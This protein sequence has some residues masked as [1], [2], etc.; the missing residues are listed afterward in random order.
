MTILPALHRAQNVLKQNPY[1]V[2]ATID[3]EGPWAAALAYTWAFPG[4]LYFFSE[5]DSRHGRALAQPSQVAGV[6]FDSRATPDMVESLQFSGRAE[7][8]HTKAAIETVLTLSAKRTGAKN[9]SN[10]TIN[11]QFMHPSTRLFRVSIE[12]SYVLNQARF[13]KDG[14]DGREQVDTE[15]VFQ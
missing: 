7:I 8:F 11:E 4:Y 13:A 9:P 3:T 12:S 2:L 10:D 5:L 6:I 1:F 15:A 14:T